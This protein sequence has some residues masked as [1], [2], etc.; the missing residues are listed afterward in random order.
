MV[1]RTWAVGNDFVRSRWCRWKVE[2]ERVW[3][4]CG[5]VCQRAGRL[6]DGWRGVSVARFT[7]LTLPRLG[8]RHPLQFLKLYT[9][10]FFRIMLLHYPC[11]FIYGTF[12]CL[13]SLSAIGKNKNRYL[14]LVCWW[15]NTLRNT[16]CPCRKIRFRNILFIFW[17]EGTCEFKVGR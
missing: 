12:T 11:E 9:D 10:A 5:P 7:S 2:K 17:V 1:W 6:W 3:W 13:S 16:C 4:K 14:K 15:L 8:G